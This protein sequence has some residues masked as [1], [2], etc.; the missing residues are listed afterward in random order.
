MQNV[1]IEIHFY[2]RGTNQ[3]SDICE[4]L[5]RSLFAHWLKLKEH[6]S[7]LFSIREVK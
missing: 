1:E 3:I 4:V 5:C 7:Q 2:L 6:E